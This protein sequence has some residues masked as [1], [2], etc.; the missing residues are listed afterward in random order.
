MVLFNGE[1]RPVVALCD[2]YKKVSSRTVK[3]RLDAGWTIEEALEITPRI[4]A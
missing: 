1:M 3:N 2:E 4:K